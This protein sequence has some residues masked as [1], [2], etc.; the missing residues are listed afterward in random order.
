M[1]ANNLLYLLLFFIS[2]QNLYAVNEDDLLDPKVAFQFSVVEQSSDAL[3]FQ[4]KVAEGYYMYRGRI[5][6][7]TKDAGVTLGKIDLPDGNKHEDEFFGEVET[8]ENAFSGS[9]PFSAAPGSQF[10]LK[11]T[12]QGCAKAG[13]CYPPQSQLIKVVVPGEQSKQ[14][15]EGLK[16][17]GA[18]MPPVGLF[19]D[20]LLP[21]EQAFV[22]EAIA[23]GSDQALVRFTMPD[24]YYLYRDKT[25]FKILAGDAKLGEVK[26]PMGDLKNDPEFGQVRV[27][28]NQVEIPVKLLREKGDATKIEL[29][30]SFQGCKENAVCYPPMQRVITLGLAAQVAP[31]SSKKE[32]GQ[33]VEQKNGSEIQESEQDQFATAL[34]GDSVFTALGL[35]FIAGLL[36]AFTPCVF[37]MLP[38]LSGIIAGQGDNVTVRKGFLLSLAYVLA[39]A[40]TYTIAGVVAGVAGQNLQAAFQNPW[41]LSVFAGIFVVL[42]L[43]MFGFFELQL[44]NSLQTK[45]TNISNRQEGGSYAGAAIMGLL[46]ALIVGPCVAPP[47]MGALI[48]I[49]EKQDP[50]LGGFALFTMA[51][52]M[53]VPLLLLGASA[54]KL[55][56]KAGMWM[57]SVK[58]VFGVMLLGLALWMLERILPGQVMMLLWGLLLVVSGVYLRAIDAL[59]DGVSGWRRLW[60]GIGVVLLMLGL[61]EIYGGLSG[62]DD[63]LKPVQA[64]VARMAGGEAVKHELEFKTIYSVQELDQLLASAKKNN[65]ALMLDFYADWCVECKR[66]EK[67]TFRNPEVIRALE[68]V[69]LVKADVTKNDAANQVLLKKFGLIGPPATIFYLPD[70]T[71]VKASRLVGYLASEDFINHVKKAIK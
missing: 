63:Y 57:D 10:D 29:E 55:L 26:L 44:P 43:S 37:P 50:V 40:L 22:Y 19:G 45:L 6:F 21:A 20:D 23:D 8:Y 11:V 1:K 58:A 65:Q 32:P 2:S 35:F 53:G 38:I 7:K 51:M 49:S 3:H 60:K 31:N 71:E 25:S 18:D 52:G 4:W 33:T 12:S 39:M 59:P 27:Y 28:H 61:L 30:A 67:T 54:G 48:Y 70:S 9:L 62:G 47:L 66:M 15:L 36:L 64:P 24:S 42:S 68:D 14:G 5:K 41:V 34:S 13:V 46:S 56:P 17:G 16:L 69:L